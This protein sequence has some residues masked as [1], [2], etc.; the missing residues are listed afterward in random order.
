MVE[1]VWAVEDDRKTLLRIMASLVGM[2]GAFTSPFEGGGRRE[3]SGGGPAP[4]VEGRSTP[5]ALP[6]FLYRAM[7]KILRPAE[8]AARR[9]IIAFSRD[10]KPPPPTPRPQKPLAPP[11]LRDSFGNP[12]VLPDGFAISG[13]LFRTS[14]KPIRTSGSPGRPRKLTLPLFDPLPEYG[15]GFVL[16]TAQPRLWVA[17][18][19]ARRPLPPRPKASDTVDATRLWRRIDAVFSALTDFE[20]HATRYARWRERTKQALAQGKSCKRIYPLRP[21]LL[22]G[23]GSALARDVHALLKHTQSFAYYALNYPD[24]S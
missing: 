7:L 14:G 15:H 4:G 16:R 24:D 1:P 3:A 11:I 23:G 10:I 21:G 6:R 5:A 9:L 8:Y 2:A 19:T 22:P 20:A 18:E 12:I 17:G 13:H